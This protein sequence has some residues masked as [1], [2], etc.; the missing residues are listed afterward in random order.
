[1]LPLR[2]MPSTSYFLIFLSHQ[3]HH[4]HR[5][6]SSCVKRKEVKH[7]FTT[8][9]F[10]LSSRM[11]STRRTGLWPTQWGRKSPSPSSPMIWT[12]RS[13]TSHLVEEIVTLRGIC[14]RQGAKSAG[15]G[16]RR[17]RMQPRLLI[18]WAAYL[19][20][21]LLRCLA[22]R[23]SSITRPGHQFPCTIQRVSGLG[24]LCVCGVV[25]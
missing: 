7:W 20:L 19:L 3:H 13:P 25:A 24:S 15:L 5:Y 11:P 22:T 21:L 14:S 18:R 12:S 10:L 1:M 23:M 4:H 17:G 2:T 16:F 9:M 6:W 8:K